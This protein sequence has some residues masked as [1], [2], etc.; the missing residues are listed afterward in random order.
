MTTARPDPSASHPSASDPSAGDVLVVGEALVDIVRTPDG[1]VSEHAGGSPANVA[2]TLGRLGR[3]TRLLTRVGDDE[4]GRGIVD[5]LAASGVA[6]AAGSVVPAP[7]STAA[8]QLD[9]HGGATYTFDLVWDLPGSSGDPTT[10]VTADA[11]GTPPRCL[12]TG[13]ISAVLEPGATAVRRLFAAARA[14]ATTSYDPNLR[15]ALMGSPEQVRPAVE[16]LVAGADVVKLSDEDARWLDP[17]TTPDELA[18]LWS[19]LG[20]AVVVVTRGGSGAKAWCAAGVVDVAG[21]PVQVADTVGAGDSFSGG[22]IDAL[23]ARDLLGAAQ[24]DALVAI[25]TDTLRAVVEHAV[26]VSAVT[27]SRPGADPP[28]RAELEAPAPVA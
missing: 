15:P 7:T 12:H 24:R 28:T 14:T 21:R 18:Q 1:R 22:L 8:A 6:L 20:P 3:P 2:L 10:D 26:A 19:R 5:H 9:S 13:S 17:G 11:T 16:H 4:R 27:V 23:W 25:D